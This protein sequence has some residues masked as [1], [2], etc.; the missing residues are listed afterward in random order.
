LARHSPTHAAPLTDPSAIDG[1][2]CAS[3]ALIHRL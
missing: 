1:M 2:S 3:G